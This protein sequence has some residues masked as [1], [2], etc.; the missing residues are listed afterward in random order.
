MWKER[1]T[2]ENFVVKKCLY[3]CP[4]FFLNF[5]AELLFIY[6]INNSLFS[7]IVIRMEQKNWSSDTLFC[8][9]Y[10]ENLQGNLSFLAS[11]YSLSLWLMLLSHSASY[12]FV[13][14]VSVQACFL[15]WIAI[16]APPVV[17]R[18]RML[19]FPLIGR[20]SIQL[21][22]VSRWVEQRERE[23][24]QLL[25]LIFHNLY[26]VLFL[27]IKSANF[28]ENNFL[29][30]LMF[31]TMAFMLQLRLLH[32]ILMGALPKPQWGGIMLFIWKD[33]I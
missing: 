22:S 33:V 25:S 2:G 30:I 18:C 1:K 23:R 3:P 5:S 27:V 7:L 20:F 14:F 9:W 10:Q 31:R 16:C 28:S 19:P 21:F 32:L 11:S 8:F 26:H 4:S 29:A 15:Y 17:C 13:M 12:I 24:E 6:L